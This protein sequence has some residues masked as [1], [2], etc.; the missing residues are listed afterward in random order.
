MCEGC[1]DPVPQWPASIAS[2]L[3]VGLLIRDFALYPESALRGLP[4]DDLEVPPV[5]RTTAWAK[6][7]PTN[8]YRIA[9]WNTCE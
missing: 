3:L 8:G 4:A 1:D 2:L 5:V 7:S 6:A 9:I